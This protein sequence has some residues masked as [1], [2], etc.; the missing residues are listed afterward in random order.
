MY[1]S[2][3]NFEKQ[4]STVVKGSFCHL[5]LIAK[6]KQLLSPKDLETI[7]HVLTTSHLDCCNSLYCGLPQTEIS[8][9]RIVQ[10]AAEFLTAQKRGITF[11]PFFS[12]LTLASC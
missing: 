7:I 3:L 6:L 8:R 10:N 12:D 1:D 2:S 9:L 11:L 4:I 5:R